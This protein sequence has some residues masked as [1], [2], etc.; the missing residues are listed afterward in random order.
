VRAEAAVLGREHHGADDVA[1]QQVGRELDALELDAEGGAEG[2]DEQGLGEAGHAFEEDV[3]VGEEGDE[4][5]LNDGVLA[6]DGF[7]DFFT[8]FLGPSGT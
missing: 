8:Q 2:F 5:A 1:G 6:D 4:Q 7:A 3:A